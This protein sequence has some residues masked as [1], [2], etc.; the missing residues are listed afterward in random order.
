MAILP[1]VK[2]HYGRL[3]FFINGEWI[4]S[5]SNNCFENTNPATGDVIAEV[6]VATEAEVEAAINSAWNAFKKWSNMP[7]RDRADYIN[8][9]RAKFDEHHEELSRILSQDHGRGIDDARGTIDRCIENIE[10]ASGAMYSL[11]KGEHVEQLATGIDCYLM[12]EP[13]GVFLILTPGNIPMHA[14]S[15]FVPYALACGCPVIVAPSW[16][17]PVASEAMF[18]IADEVGFP[19]GVLNL[20][21]V[22]TNF[23]LNSRIISD[24]RVAG[25]G[26][27]GST[28]VGRELFELCGRL[29]KRSSI[30]GNGKNHIVV[31]PDGNLDA[32]ANYLLRGCFGMT[33]QRCLGSDNVAVIGN[34][35]DD[36]KD[37]FLQA[38][39]AMKVGFGLDETSEMGP[40]TTLSN[41]KKVE[42]FIEKGL[43]EGAKLIL[44]GRELKVKGYENG[45]FLGPSIFEGVSPSMEIAK[46]ESF[47]PVSNLIRADS[48]EQVIEWINTNTE[49]GHSA[50]LITESG[51]NARK[52]IRECNVGNVGINAGIPQP[53]AFFPLGSKRQSFFGVAKSRMDSVRMFLDQKTVTLRW[54]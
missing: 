29:G 33:G 16:Q 11:Y 37:K 45:Y 32:A 20:L 14:W 41:K 5:K 21:H 52:F 44:D 48:L 22:G 39:K 17:C 51:K 4:E 31:A 25:V 26:F 38:A 50:C 46:E 13:V 47:G 19:P 54:V 36:L 40:L 7:F 23:E 49:F 9:L 3:K 43:N 53:Y 30:N 6:P 35:Y 18:K 2:K 12:W 15:S 42:N 28:A 8:R 27:I 34:I 24:S 1:E 10:S